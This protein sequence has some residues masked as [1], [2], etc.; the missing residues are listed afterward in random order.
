MDDKDPS[1]WA[2]L[3]G[4]LLNL[5]GYLTELRLC[6]LG[7]RKR[8]AETYARVKIH[9]V[10]VFFCFLWLLLLLLLLDKQFS[11][12]L[13]ETGSLKEVEKRGSRAVWSN[14]FV[15]SAV[16]IYGTEFN[17]PLLV[18]ALLTCAAWLSKCIFLSPSLVLIKIRDD[19]LQVHRESERASSFN[20]LREDENFATIDLA[21]LFYN[22]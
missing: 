18:R 19:W 6:N 9:P 17:Q 5:L 21:Q 7:N 11:V 16:C 1:V 10:L 15:R 8:L 4:E 22:L 20:A 12:G 3:V 2:L 13:L 14:G